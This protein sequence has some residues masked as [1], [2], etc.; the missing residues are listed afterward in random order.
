[1]RYLRDQVGVMRDIYREHGPIA[2]L[3]GGRTDVIFAFGPTF[4]HL[5]MSDPTRFYSGGITY[6]GPPDSAQRR[7]GA[8]LLTMNGEQHRRQRRLILPVFH[9]TYLEVY[10][11]DMVVLT[12]QMLDRWALGERLDAA[13]EIEPPELRHALIGGLDD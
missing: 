7:L 9:K 4:N 6:S 3:T 12:Q 2:A 1:M 8:G 11:N 10:Y 5:L 13:R